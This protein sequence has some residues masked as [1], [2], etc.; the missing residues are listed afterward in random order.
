MDLESVLT[1]WVPCRERCRCRL[2]GNRLGGGLGLLLACS[3]WSTQYLT[4]GG[5]SAL[6][7]LPRETRVPSSQAGFNSIARYVIPARFAEARDVGQAYFG[8]A[9][10]LHRDLGVFEKC[11]VAAKGAGSDP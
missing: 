4:A 8:L 1:E 9:R 11:R 7:A 3:V 2:L 6:L 5:R 10:F